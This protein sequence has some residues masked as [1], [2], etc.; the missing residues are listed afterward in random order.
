M[1]LNDRQIKNAKPTDKPYKLTDG[2]GLHLVITPAG[3]KLWRLKYRIDGKEKLLSIGKYPTIALIEARQAAEDARRMI[4]NGQDPA[5]AKQEA[6]QAKQAAMLNTFASLAM[7]WH[8][9]NIH[10]WKPIHAARIVKDLEKD[11]FPHI[12]QR[13]LDE[14]SV[15]DVKA[16]IE[17][18]AARGAY[19]SAEK[20]RQW[21]GAV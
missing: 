2:G 13:Q 18:I 8:A 12:G 6:K 14:I 1:P 4:A 5:A 17:R 21:I 15:S 9:A 3:G 20:V 7:Q 10:R 11:V 16:L 19:V